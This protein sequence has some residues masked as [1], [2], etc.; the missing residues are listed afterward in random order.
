M[1]LSDDRRNLNN[2]LDEK[3]RPKC[4]PL[5]SY[6]IFKSTNTHEKK[7]NN[8]DKTLIATACEDK[9]LKFPPY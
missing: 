9:K 4:C 8:G 5:N 6:K 7:R 2:I 3:S 1:G